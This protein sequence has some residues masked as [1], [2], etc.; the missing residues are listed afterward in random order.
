MNHDIAIIRPQV[1]LEDIRL[2]GKGIP[3]A[4]LKRIRR[5]LWTLTNLELM[6]QTVYRYELT[7]ERSEFNRQV[8]AAMLNEMTHFQDFQV[9]TY[10]Y[11]WYPALVRFGYWWVG[12]FFGVSSRLCGQR[13]VLR[14]NIWLEEK[15]V[16]HYTE[17]LR[18]DIWDA[19]TRRVLEK[20]LADEIGHVERWQRLLAELH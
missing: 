19:D 5:S 9:K 20:D 6:A 14:T 18:S 7:S 16:S 8:I 10:E 3:A 11:G 4:Q 12:W 1:R 15:A 13:A 17:F 2:R